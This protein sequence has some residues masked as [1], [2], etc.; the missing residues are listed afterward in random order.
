MIIK[1]LSWFRRTIALF[2]IGIIFRPI[3]FFLK[4]I[5]KYGGKFIILK[6]YKIYRPIKAYF[7]TEFVKNKFLALFGKR[8]V[9]HLVI[10][11]IAIFVTTSNISAREKDSVLLKFE[12]ESIISELVKEGEFDDAPEIIEEIID[13]NKIGTQKIA[14]YYFDENKGVLVYNPQLSTTEDDAGE[15]Y[16]DSN[17]ISGSSIINTDVT[18]KERTETIVYEVQ[19]G[20]TVS[21]IAKQFNITSKTIIW[22][23]D[24]GN[25]GF[26]K[27]GQKLTILPVTGISYTVKKYDTIGKIS[28]KYDVSESEIMHINDIASASSLQIG[29]KLIIPGGVITTPVVSNTTVVRTKPATQEKVKIASAIKSTTSLQWPASCNVITQYFF[30]GHQGL[31][32][33]CK[34]GTP[35]YA[36]EDG[37]VETSGWMTGY[38]KMIK[39]RHS[40]S[41]ETLYG[42]FSTLLVQSGE[43]VNRG[44]VIG[45]MGSTGWST[46]SHLHFEVRVGNAKKNPLSYL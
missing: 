33:A 34:L 20:D 3:G 7:S 44:D 6:L 4:F 29:Q 28:N 32:I 41:M 13:I 11:I 40:S 22:E 10:I 16:D 43:A 23:N 19:T 39:I 38:G 46:G 42:H 9:I 27:P 37:V 8:Y 18:P 5:Y 31:D 12:G 14:N 24:L 26:I 1:G 15:I 45:L 36:A 25:N 30:Y 21:S 17:V 2:F 35:I